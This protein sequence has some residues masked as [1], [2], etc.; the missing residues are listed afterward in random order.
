MLHDL[1]TCSTTWQPGRNIWVP[2]GWLC[3]SVGPPIEWLLLFE[4]YLNQEVNKFSSQ[5][6]INFRNK[7]RWQ[8]CYACWKLENNAH[9]QSILMPYFMNCRKGLT[10]NVRHR[11]YGELMWKHMVWGFQNDIIY[12]SIFYLSSYITEL[13]S[14][15]SMLVPWH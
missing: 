15:L 10:S 6:L 4:P 14:D 11:H 12:V 9:Q 7:F 2:Q 3:W 1:Y 13:Y 8:L 5:I